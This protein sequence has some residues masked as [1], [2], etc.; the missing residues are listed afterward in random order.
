MKNFA[1]AAIALA[2]CSAPA[3]AD[4]KPAEDEAGKIKQTLSDWGCEGGTFEKETE[5]SSLFE[6]DDVKCKDGNQ[7]DV[8]LDGSFKVISITRD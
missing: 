5:A 1:I 7:Y 3:F 2:F 6:A 4:S 8:K